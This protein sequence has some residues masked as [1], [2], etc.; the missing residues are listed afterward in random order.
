[1]VKAAP[2]MGTDLLHATR[3]VGRRRLEKVSARRRDDCGLWAVVLMPAAV[4]ASGVGDWLF[5]RLARDQDMTTDVTHRM[6]RAV[7]A[8]I[9]ED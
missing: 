3:L 1:M 4:G 7:F 6:H 8:G 9:Y 2:L 5:A